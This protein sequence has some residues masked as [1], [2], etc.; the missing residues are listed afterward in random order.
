[1]LWLCSNFDVPHGD[2]L[3]FS[4]RLGN[5]HATR[6]APRAPESC[7]SSSTVAPPRATRASNRVPW[8][9]IK[10]SKASREFCGTELCSLRCDDTEASSTRAAGVGRSD[11]SALARLGPMAIRQRRQDNARTFSGWA[12]RLGL[13]PESASVRQ[14]IHKILMLRTC[15]Q[16]RQLSPWKANAFLGK[17]R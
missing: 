12:S 14:N 5:R 4:R 1:M 2:C 8:K 15:R 16:S 9:H 11:R 13:R 17:S 10:A 6:F 3:R 7:S